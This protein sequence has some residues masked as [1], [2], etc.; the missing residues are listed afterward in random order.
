MTRCKIR[1]PVYPD[2]N[3]ERPSNNSIVENGRKFLKGLTI[4]KKS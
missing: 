1:V 3:N 4:L 2:K